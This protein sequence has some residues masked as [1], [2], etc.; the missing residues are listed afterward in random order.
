MSVTILKKNKYGFLNTIYPNKII[1]IH[2]S[3][4]LKNN[5]KCNLCT[6]IPVLYKIILN[7][8]T[9]MQKTMYICYDCSNDENLIIN[10]VHYGIANIFKTHENTYP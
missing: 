3:Q 9:R 4:Q 5:I 10:N 1:C 6:N 2:G 8:Y 7:K